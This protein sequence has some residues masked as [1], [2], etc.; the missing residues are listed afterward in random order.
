MAN[1]QQQKNPATTMSLELTY[2]ADFRT[3]AKSEG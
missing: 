1:S 3:H 2:I